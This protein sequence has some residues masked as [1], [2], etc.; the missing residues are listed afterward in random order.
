MSPA[1]QSTPVSNLDAL[2]RGMQP[3]RKPGVYAYVQVPA[4]Q[5]WPDGLTVLASVVEAEGTTLV[6]PEPEAERL[7]LPIHFRA[8]WIALTIHSDLAACGLTAAVARVLADAGIACNVIAGTCHDHLLV[9]VDRANDALEALLALQ[10][11]RTAGKVPCAN[12]GAP[13]DSAFC[14]ACGQ[15]RFVES[16]RRMAHLAR[17]FFDNLTSLDSRFWRSLFGLLFRPGLLTR[18]YLD[19]R[20]THWMSPVSLFLLANVLYFFA[21]AITDFELPFHDQVPG[22][23]ALEIVDPEGRLDAAHRD[24][25][26]DSTG[27]YHSPWTASWVEARVAAR[28]AAARARDP[29]ARYTLRDLADA[30]DARSADVSRLLII[31]HAPV[32]ALVLALLF[33]WKR[34]YFAEHLVI[35]L[36]VFASTLYVIMGLVL[37]LSRLGDW[38]GWTTW[39]LALVAITLLPILHAVLT[40]RRCFDLAWWQALPSGFLLIVALLYANLVPYRFLQFSIVFWLA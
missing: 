22:P 3:D 2:L 27:Q 4:D 15:A 32:M 5:P 17:Q 1:P 28:D 26:R 35:A 38:T 7:R 21:P 18:D 40:L 14:P 30:Y 12:C 29:D 31:L 8:A 13:M 37:P 9:P 33:W 11:G 34:R 24:A 25:I 19:G 10:S 6:V 20:R 16:D 23:M 39:P 36:H